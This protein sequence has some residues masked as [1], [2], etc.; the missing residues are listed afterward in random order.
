MFCANLSS[1]ETNWELMVGSVE[2]SRSF[3]KSSTSFSM[4]LKDSEDI[5]WI[6]KVCE[7]SY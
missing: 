6:L 4:V 7:S 5:I 1:S 2:L 3:Q